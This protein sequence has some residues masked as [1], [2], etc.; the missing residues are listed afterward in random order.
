MDASRAEMKAVLAALNE[1]ENR[2]D[3]AAIDLVMAKNVEGWK[4]DVHTPNRAAERAVEEM[5]FAAVPDYHRVFQR[6]VIDPPFAAV[7]WRITGASSV[8]GSQIDAVGSSWFEVD[9]GKIVR[10]WLYADMT[11]LS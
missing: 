9:D 4:N 2:H 6:T 7:G 1:A 10:Y 8:N 3:P 5:L 11:P